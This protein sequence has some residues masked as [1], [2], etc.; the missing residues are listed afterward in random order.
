MTSI[1]AGLADLPN[2]LPYRLVPRRPIGSLPLRVPYWTT[3]A[4]TV[5][6]HPLLPGA[7]APVL[8]LKDGTLAMGLRISGIDQYAASDGQLNAM[9]AV[10]S[11]ALEGL[12]S[13]AYV[14]AVFESGAPFGK[15]LERFGGLSAASSSEVLRAGRRRR[16][17]ALADC[18]LLTRCEI[19]YWVGWRGALEALTGGFKGW[20]K[21][22]SGKSHLELV[23][24]GTQVL[25]DATTRF[26][27]GLRA[28]GLGVE[29]LQEVEL[30]AACHRAL[31]PTVHH[32]FPPPRFVETP[33]DLEAYRAGEPLALRGPSLAAQLCLGSVGWNA[34]QL[35]MGD[36]PILARALVVNR[37]AEVT[38]PR[39][40]HGVLFQHQP[41]RPFRLVV[42][43]NATDKTL[44][45]ERLKWRRRLVHGFLGGPLTDHRAA[46]AFADQDAL[47]EQ[48]THR[49][50]HLFET[51]IVALVH[52][53][54]EHELDQ[55]TQDV[56]DGF[57]EGNIAAG[58]LHEEQL[59]GWQSTLPANGHIAGHRFTLLDRSCAHLTPTWLPSLGDETPELLFENRQRGVEALS[60]R[61]G[62]V[63][64]QAGAVILGSTGSGKTFLFSN[65]LKYGCLDL[66]GHAVLVDVKGPTNSSYRPLCEVLG[67][68]YVCLESDAEASF[69]PFPP[70]A[71]VFGDQGEFLSEVIEPAVLAVCLMAMPSYESP[72]LDYWT[73]N[74]YAAIE[75]AYERKVG[76]AE[77]VILED[78]IDVLA[79]PVGDSPKGQTI[80]ADMRERL[81]MFLKTPLRQRLFN[82]PKTLDMSNPFTVFD[83]A[84]M[85]KDP[86]AAMVLMAGLASRIEA[87]MRRLPK[88]L[89]KL[90]G[91]DEAWKLLEDS[92][93]GCQLLGMLYRTARSYG[94]FCYVLT[95]HENDILRNRVGQAIMSN[96]SLR[97]LLRRI[98]GHQGVAQAFGLS[99]RQLELFRSLK[100]K[101]GPYAEFLLADTHEARTQVLQYWPTPFD[102]WCDTSRPADVE[103]R[104]ARLK[105]SGRALVEV[106]GE[107][108]RE[109]PRG[110]PAGTA[111]EA[112]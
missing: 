18:N 105:A 72:D 41:L 4:P 2:R 55:A 79:E 29:V 98:D 80:A 110:A 36:P 86:R 51:S 22:V 14:Q 94:A 81:T 19:T 13:D 66:G 52:G 43:H 61:L 25:A 85:D 40:L 33:D 106:I 62:P 97:Y 10:L 37:L 15:L 46:Q 75:R 71:E 68:N 20:L 27:E 47:I 42:T 57:Q 109:F 87:K 17:E 73:A 32:K 23:R 31:N 103:V 69:S 67:G 95:Q 89:P 58:I 53:Y 77:P 44:H 74:A 5:K 56:L 104:H 108:A 21:S 48:L 100:P 30:L 70:Q 65:I 28:G 93:A 63:R 49:S 35:V 111:S 107:L 8:V 12:P 112:A 64:E 24:Q 9:S 102:Y 34:S 50:A 45:L 1:L 82:A 26:A 3:L 6:P 83:F 11:R 38:T 59:Q 76:L 88:T 16:Y 78:V 92:E 7:T 54:D 90:F 96:S 101:P 84:G 91:F 39:S 99:E 60:A